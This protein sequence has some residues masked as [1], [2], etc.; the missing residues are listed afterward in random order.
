MSQ[1]YLIADTAVYETPLAARLAA[2]RTSEGQAAEHR[3]PLELKMHGGAQTPLGFHPKAA[4]LQAL[5]GAA[6]VFDLGYRTFLRATGKDRVRWLNGMITQTVKGLSPGQ[7]GYTLVLSPQGRVQ[8]DGEVSFHDEFLLLETDRSQSERLLAHLR[9]FI[10]M[11]DVK[12]EEL[13][14][15]TTALGIDGPQAAEILAGLG[16]KAPEEGR[17]ERTE[18]AA[19][20]VT[21]AHRYGPLAPRFTLQ[22]ATEQV[23]TVWKALIEA[24]AVACGVAALE[25]LR[26]LEGVAQF[27]V[28]FS[29]KHLPQET[30][31]ERALN[32]TK[33][34][35]IGQEIVERI[36]SRASVHR[37]LRQ[38]DLDGARPKLGPGEKLEL[39]AG[40][41]TVGE[42]TSVADFSLPQF[43]GA[44]GLGMVRVEALEGSPS[45][46][47]HYE[48]GTAVP[49]SAPPDLAHS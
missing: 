1:T 20:E 11:D 40:D 45:E 23:L 33:G 9:R 25:D 46:P 4:E 22:V 24:G 26:V 29:D 32:F 8:G 41:A 36:R 13:D 19:V 43:T 37:S 5:L 2:D 7:T 18:L 3:A 10:I 34:C 47:L 42:L 49:R 44:L 27:D 6:G 35:F 39:K 48:G 17:F 16:G 38:F 28:D 14:A 31:L 21:V 30:N 15:S 12:L